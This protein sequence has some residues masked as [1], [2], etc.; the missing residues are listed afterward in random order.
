MNA[1]VKKTDL[2][3]IENVQACAA[4]IIA[5]FG[6][7]S[8]SSDNGLLGCLVVAVKVALSP[9]NGPAVTRAAWLDLC[10]NMYDAIKE[11]ERQ[12]NAHQQL[13]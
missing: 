6:T 9:L 5:L 2:L 7:R 3:R 4:A 11:D 12:K 13:H 1:S 8:E 10:G